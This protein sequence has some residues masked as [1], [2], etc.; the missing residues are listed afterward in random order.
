MAIASNRFRDVFT[1]HARRCCPEAWFA[2]NVVL[3]CPSASDYHGPSRVEGDLVEIDAG[4]R[5]HLWLFTSVYS[6]DFITG[7]VIGRLFACAHAARVAS[8]QFLRS[9]IDSAA[10]RRPEHGPG[11]LPPRLRP[12]FESWNLVVTG[13]SGC[14]L[15]GRD[16]NPLHRL[17]A[18]LSAAIG[19]VGDINVWQFYQTSTGYDLRSLWDMAAYSQPSLTELMDRAMALPVP[20]D[21]FDI[22]CKRDLHLRRR[23]GFHVEGLAAWLGDNRQGHDQDHRQALAG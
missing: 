16:D 17:Y 2:D 7:A 14:E 8:P 3:P 20:G 10:R 19:T 12:A 1:T 15:A 9:R 23:K 18:P 6:A 21:D 22:A 13:G 11:P 5:M 4:G